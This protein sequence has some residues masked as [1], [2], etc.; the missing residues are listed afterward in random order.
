[1]KICKT[2]CLCWLLLFPIILCYASGERPYWMHQAT[3]GMN[4]SHLPRV[5]ETF[6][7]TYTYTP[8]N[9][10]NSVIYPKEMK[11]TFIG[12][13]THSGP[14]SHDFYE[15]VTGQVTNEFSE[16]Q[17]DVPT[18]FTISLRITKPIAKV[19]LRGYVPGYPAWI[20]RI[21]LFLLDSI[22]GQYGTGEQFLKK[23]V[24]IE[25]RYDACDGSFTEPCYAL[26]LFEQNR[27]IISMMKQLEPKLSDSLALLLHSDQYRI[28]APPGLPRWD[29]ENNRWIEEELFEYYLRDGWY[30][31]VREGTHEE[32]IEQEREKIMKEHEKKDY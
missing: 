7:L 23:Y 8:L 26:Q 3:A 14:R 29:D 13:E 25:Y 31:A 24:P 18:E 15:I 17:Q 9:D 27:A 2:S 10:P 32:W 11:F 5:N 30:D 1:M 21:E 22:S 4:I 16:L 12:Y 20:S 6:T 28:G 19:I